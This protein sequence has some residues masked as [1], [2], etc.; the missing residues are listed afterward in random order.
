MMK[1]DKKS[2]IILVLLGVS[3]IFFG[4]WYFKGDDTKNKIKELESKNRK[5]EVTR[6][7]LDNVNKSLKLD[8][9][10]IQIVINDREEFIKQIEQNLSKVKLELDNANIKVKDGQKALSETKKKIEQLKRNPINRTDDSLINS[11]KEKLKK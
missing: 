8:F 3:V 6:D 2:I 5:I 9:D 11:L 1:L 4:L 10:K 7:S